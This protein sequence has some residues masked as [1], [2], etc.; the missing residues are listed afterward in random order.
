M[1]G[2]SLILNHHKHG[3]IQPIVLVIL[4]GFGLTPPYRGNAITLART[5]NFNRLVSHYRAV[6]LQASGEVVGLPWGEMGNSEVGHLSLGSGQIVYQTLP[7]IMRAISDGSFF[8]NEAFLS[9]IEHAQKNQST[10]H[11]IGL[12]SRGGVH[13]AI[14]HVF[15]LLEFCVSRSFERVVV[16]AFLD[17]RDTPHNS[18]RKFIQ[19]LEEK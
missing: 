18:A 12:V 9:A 7:R 5:P 3:S 15:G 8:T 16:H 14:E 19:E 13:S 10:L 17:G 1:T 11:L 4:D 2:H 6:S